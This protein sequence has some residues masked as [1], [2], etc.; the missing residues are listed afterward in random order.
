MYRKEENGEKEQL[1]IAEN[2]KCFDEIS[3]V[4]DNSKRVHWR[5]SVQKAQKNPVFN[6]K[7]SFELVAEDST[8]RLVF[9]VWHRDFVKERSELIGCMSFSIRHVLDDA[10]KIDGWYR[11]L[12]EGFGTQKHFAA[13]VRKNQCAAK[14]VK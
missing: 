10:Q 4:P 7:F 14:H 11:L 13:H 9:S 3:L 2:T 1:A 5:T 8:K 6:Q 12:R